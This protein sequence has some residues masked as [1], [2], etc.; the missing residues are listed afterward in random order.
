MFKGHISLQKARNGDLRNHLLDPVQRFQ[1]K[2]SNI[3]HIKTSFLVSK[4]TKL[5]D[6]QPA[7]SSE[8]EDNEAAAGSDAQDED[9][10]VVPRKAESGSEESDSGSEDQ[11]REAVKRKAP[12]AKVAEG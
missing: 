3:Q 2:E 4:L 7:S 12:A 9:E 6:A 11:G 8:S 1:H 10:V 5:P